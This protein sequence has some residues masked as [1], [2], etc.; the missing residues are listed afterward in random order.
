MAAAKI[1]SKGQITIPVRIRA[2]L[3]VGAGDRIEFME[4][5]KGKVV[6]IPATRS[7]RELN[8]M[9]RGR[10]SKPLTIEEMDDVI[11]KRASESR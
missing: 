7:V 2:V 10:R 4:L 11:A 6:M 9:F 3:G 1:T 8:G 5:E